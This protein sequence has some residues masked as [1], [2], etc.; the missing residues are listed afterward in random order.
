MAEDREDV[1]PRLEGDIRWNIISSLQIEGKIL[2]VTNSIG[3]KFNL[4]SL[5]GE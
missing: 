4:D 2:V 1:D 3:E 5:T